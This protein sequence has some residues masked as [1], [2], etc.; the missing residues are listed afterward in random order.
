MEIGALSIRIESLRVL[1]IDI[2][3]TEFIGARCFI[4]I[5]PSIPGIGMTRRLKCPQLA[6]FNLHLQILTNIA[7]CHFVDFKLC[8]NLPCTPTR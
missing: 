4:E 8:G 1:R 7:D 5:C 3:H 6:G 2:Q